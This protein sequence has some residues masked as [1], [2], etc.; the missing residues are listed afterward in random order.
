MVGIIKRVLSPCQKVIEYIC[1]GLVNC[2]HPQR[3]Q[4]IV[5]ALVPFPAA[6]H[7]GYVFNVFVGLR[8]LLAEV[9]T[10]EPL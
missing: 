2:G 6:F 3:S 4:L 10:S 9:Q 5:K 8:L 1:K 7:E